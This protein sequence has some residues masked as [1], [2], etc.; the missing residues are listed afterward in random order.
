M[1]TVSTQ[2]RKY[3]LQARAD[4]QQET[5]ERIVAATMGLHRKVGPAKT[6]IADIA[7]NAG[8]QRLTVYNHFPTLGDLLGACQGHFLGLHPV[9]D[10]TPGVPRERAR[11]RLESALTDLYVW[12]RAN[13]QMT[14][15]IRNDRNVVPELD[16]LLR[17]TLDLALD[18]TA[19]AYAKLLGAST[20]PLIRV[21]LEFRT[22]ELLADTG[23]ADAAIARLFARAKPS[24]A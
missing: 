11:A 6:T 4:R 8:V 18:G 12:Y 24:P 5:R 19:D 14:R 10:L 21:A 7:R 13:Q 17:R 9:P 16:A 23:M 2:K 3:R 1:N 20:R 22:W 15:H